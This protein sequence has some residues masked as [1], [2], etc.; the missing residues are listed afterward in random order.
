MNSAQ[1][2][3]NVTDAIQVTISLLFLFFPKIFSTILV[4]VFRPTSPYRFFEPGF[5]RW[6]RIFS[7]ISLVFMGALA[8]LI[9]FHVGGTGHAHE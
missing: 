2:F 9:H 4:K 3:S 1:I 6:V 8:L 7:V 5:L